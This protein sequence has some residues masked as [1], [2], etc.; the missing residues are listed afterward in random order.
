MTKQLT[1]WTWGLLLGILIVSSTVIPAFASTQRSTG[2][3]MF[4]SSFSVEES[5]QRLEAELK[6]R[7]LTLVAKVDHAAAANKVGLELR[8]TQVFIFGNPRG[9]TPL[10]QC[11]QITGID[12]PLKAL[13]WQEKEGTVWVGYNTPSYLRVRHGLKQCKPSLSQNLKQIDQ[14]L[15]AIALAVT[16]P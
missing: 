9:G 2:V 5:A 15:Q 6:S 10:M 13:I 1:R 16:R 11:N 4:K 8:P 3:A 7:N 12:L 14:T